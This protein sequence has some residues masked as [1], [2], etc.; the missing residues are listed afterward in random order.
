M[1]AI[2]YGSNSILMNLGI[3]T[4]LIDYDNYAVE[5]AIIREIFDE[6]ENEINSYNFN[7]YNIYLKCGYYEGFYLSIENT[8]D[9]YD[10]ENDRLCNLKELMQVRELLIK[11]C[12]LGMVSYTPGYCMSFKDYKNTIYEIEEAIAVESIRINDLLLDNEIT[13]KMWREGIL[14][15]SQLKK[16]LDY[17]TGGNYE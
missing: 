16:Y 8:I 9:V 10:D 13:F 3:N 1:G 14:K 12:L 11:L 7:Y 4:N 5:E 17:F 2:N 15:K 6:A